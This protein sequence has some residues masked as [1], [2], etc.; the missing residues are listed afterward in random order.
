MDNKQLFQTR[1]NFDLIKDV[2]TLYLLLEDNK[3][4]HYLSSR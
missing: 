1:N 4:I 2:E 3:I